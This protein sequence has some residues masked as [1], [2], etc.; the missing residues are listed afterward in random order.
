M[1]DQV[2]AEL[3]KRQMEWA[4]DALSQPVGRDAYDFGHAA[5]VLLGLKMAEA[6]VFDVV[7]GDEDKRNSW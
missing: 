7:K 4:H 1:I 5:G 2:V 3:R 6:I